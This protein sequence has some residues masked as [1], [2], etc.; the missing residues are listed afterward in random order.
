M[1]DLRSIK[2]QRSLFDRR[3]DQDNRQRYDSRIVDALGYDRR[4][5]GFERRKKPEQREGWVRVSQWSSVC[6]AALS[7]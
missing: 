1:V 6:V 5:P 2:K 7:S 4:K 3:S